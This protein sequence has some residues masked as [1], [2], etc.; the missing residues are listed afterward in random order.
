MHHCGLPWSFSHHLSSQ[1]ERLR[2]DDDLERP[3]ARR[4]GEG[5]IGVQDLAESEAVRDQELRL[6][7]FRLDGLEQ[8]GRGDRVNEPGR[9]GD[10]ARPEAFQ[11]QIDLAPVHSNIGDDPAGRHE[12]LAEHE[13]R[14]HTDRLDRG[15]DSA[16]A[17]KR[18]DLFNRRPVAVVDRLR[19]AESTCDFQPV[20]VEIDHDDLGGE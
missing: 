19:C 10:V 6:E 8:H 3:R 4:A 12:V 1:T 14:W 9:D 18:S 16:P 2:F 17:G 20:V 15:I 13:S 11:M 5:V 7:L